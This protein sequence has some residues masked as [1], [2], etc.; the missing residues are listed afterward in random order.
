[1]RTATSIIGIAT[2]PARRDPC[3]VREP[4]PA[5]NNVAR[6]EMASAHSAFSGLCIQDNGPSTARTAS[7][8]ALA[9]AT[10]KNMPLRNRTNPNCKCARR[11]ERAN[12]CPI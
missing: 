6:T 3:I 1:M 4:G 12:R 9:T 10:A 5:I 2:H 11:T 8:T 7:K